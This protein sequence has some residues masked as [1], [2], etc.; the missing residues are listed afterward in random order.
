MRPLISLDI[1]T[2]LFIYL[3][4]SVIAVLILWM[5]RGLRQKETVFKEEEDYIRHC[6]ICAFEY[7]DSKEENISKCPQCGSL[8]SKDAVVNSKDVIQRAN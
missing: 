2:A 8:N 3:L 7:V 4:C 5:F 6:E 1:S